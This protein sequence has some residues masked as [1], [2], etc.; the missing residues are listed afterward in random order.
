M[1]KPLTTTEFGGI[2]YT[3]VHFLELLKT[4]KVHE[5]TLF[6]AFNKKGEEKISVVIVSDKDEKSYGGFSALIPLQAL[7]GIDID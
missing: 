1:K 6:G 7:E 4:K 2:L 5:S 3:K